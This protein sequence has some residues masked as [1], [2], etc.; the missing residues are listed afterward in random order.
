[1]KIL[2]LL[3][4]DIYLN[5]GVTKKVESQTITWSK[6]GH[7][8]KVFNILL[9]SNI[10]DGKTSLRAEI[11]FRRNPLSCSKYFQKEVNKFNPDIIYF[12]FEPYKPFFVKLFRQYSTVF[13]L[14]T[15]DVA[16]QRMEAKQNYKKLIRY[17]FNSMTRNLILKYAKGFVGVTNEICNSPHY[18]KYNV[19][20]ITI[21]NSINLDNYKVLKVKNEHKKPQVLFM[22]KPGF[23]W[24]GIDKIIKLA[25]NTID[26]LDFHIVGYESPYETKLSP[27]IHFY[28]FIP[29]DKYIKIIEQCDVGIASSAFHR[30]PISEASPL[31]VREYLTY[32]LPVI[33]PYKDTMLAQDINH[34]EWILELPNN[35]DN[36]LGNKDIIINFCRKMKD[37]VLYKKDIETLISSDLLE[38][39]KLS[40]FEKILHCNE[41][42]TQH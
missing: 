41:N 31:K 34:Y 32:G 28:G 8:I 38:M 17:I 23:E 2:Y 18:K 22:G 9:K 13:E 12:R 42:K 15:D 21:P 10:Q 11:F 20:S 6:Y 14:N 26:E 29:K 25:S 33:L 3:S 1:M 24:H 27:N 4:H 37:V 5:D 35:E 36:L 40:F 39:R 16:E 30:I 7:Q 19:P